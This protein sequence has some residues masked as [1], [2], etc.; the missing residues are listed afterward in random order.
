MFS[1]TRSLHVSLCCVAEK[2][3]SYS[4]RLDF[5]RHMKIVVMSK[6]MFSYERHTTNK[7]GSQGK[8][9]QYEVILQCLSSRTFLVGCVSF[10]AKHHFGQ[11][12]SFHMPAK[13]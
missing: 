11:Y 6:V 8:S 2:H 9:L 7:E 4:C 1:L 13:I 3:S 12:D 10:V 5:C